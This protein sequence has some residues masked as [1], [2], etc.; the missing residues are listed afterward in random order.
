[1]TGL[2]VAVATRGTRPFTRAWAGR[3]AVVLLALLLLGGYTVGAI[4]ARDPD[5]R[6]R[7]SAPPADPLA[8]LARP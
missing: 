4:R 8:P 1:M 2:G 6:A 7:Y 5:E 3:A